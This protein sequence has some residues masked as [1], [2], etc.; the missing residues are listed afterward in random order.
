M[1]AASEINPFELKEVDTK[2]YYMSSGSSEF[3]LDGDE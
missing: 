2:P 1:R 3:S